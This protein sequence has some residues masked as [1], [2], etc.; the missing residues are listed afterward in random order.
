MLAHQHPISRSREKVCIGKLPDD[1]GAELL[2]GC[3]CVGTC[4]HCRGNFQHSCRKHQS[5]YGTVHANSTWTFASQRLRLI[6]WNIA[7]ILFGGTK[8][9]SRLAI[10]PPRTDATTFG[11]GPKRLP[12]TGKTCVPLHNYLP[13]AQA[14]VLL[15]LQRVTSATPCVSRCRTVQKDII[16]ERGYHT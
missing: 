11:P 7:Q 5:R 13:G 6:T 9:L 14:A 12:S 10:D 15:T 4:Q 16:V 8:A 3:S 1:L 2:R